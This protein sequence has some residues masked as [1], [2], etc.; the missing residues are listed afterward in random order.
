MS[1]GAA[2]YETDCGVLAEY[3]STTSGEEGIPPNIRNFLL[4]GRPGIV[5][6]T[7]AEAVIRELEED[8]GGF[9]TG[10]SARVALERASALRPS[11]AGRQLWHPSGSRRL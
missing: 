8:A 2:E 5:K 3:E 6:T 7:V 1:E 10:R 9:V 11:R 4:T